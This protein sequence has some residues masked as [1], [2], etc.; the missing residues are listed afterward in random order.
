M[1]RSIEKP[2]KL[3]LPRGRGDNFDLTDLTGLMSTE[4][5][6]DEVSVSASQ[7]YWTRS[8]PPPPI[9]LSSQYWSHYTKAYGDEANQQYTAAAQNS[10]SLDL[11]GSHKKGWWK[12]RQP[13]HIA[14]IQQAR[15][16]IALIW[17]P[18]PLTVGLDDLN[19]VFQPKW[20][21]NST[22]TTTRTG[23]SFRRFV[24]TQKFH[25]ICYQYI[26]SIQHSKCLSQKTT[27]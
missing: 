2:R 7:S 10:H 25:R 11:K 13:I 9:Y 12:Q 18:Q 23:V 6:V 14:C 3:G 1:Y 16:S 21:Y 4:R 26:K 15:F 22:N 20:F 8:I 5:S 24:L 19:S 17:S 27:R